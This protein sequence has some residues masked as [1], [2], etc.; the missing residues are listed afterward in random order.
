[1]FTAQ[2]DRGVD[3]TG[4]S[5]DDLQTV[6]FIVSKQFGSLDVSF[7][8]QDVFDREFEIIP[9]YGAGGRNFFLTLSYK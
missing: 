1:M 9:G 7:T 5:I 4:N 2:Y 6:D 3:F 8:V